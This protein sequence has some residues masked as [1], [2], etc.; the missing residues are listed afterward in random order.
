MNRTI[1]IT[2]GVHHVW[3]LVIRSCMNKYI[4]E[5]L[6]LFGI[7]GCC[8]LLPIS[9]ISNKMRTT[10]A[11]QPKYFSQNQFDVENK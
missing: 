1:V 11:K 3:T 10:Y 7:R 8:W 4:F 2:N 9:C 6:L 5:V